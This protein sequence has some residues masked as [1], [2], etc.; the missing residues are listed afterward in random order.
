L[1]IVALGMVLVW[2]VEL[3]GAAGVFLAGGS[4]FVTGYTGPKKRRD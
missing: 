4:H 3:E 1:R 2:V